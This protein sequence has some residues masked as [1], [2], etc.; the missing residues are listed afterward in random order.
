MCNLI[1]AAW[2][3]SGERRADAWR[4]R[5]MRSKTV[6]WRHG[7]GIEVKMSDGRKGNRSIVSTLG[8]DEEV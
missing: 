6:A 1:N 2:D 5:R 7:P 8:N 4:I 3:S